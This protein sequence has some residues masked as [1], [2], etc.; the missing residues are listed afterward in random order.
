MAPRPPESKAQFIARLEQGAAEGRDQIRF[1]AP[2]HTGA[3]CREPGGW[4]VRRL[5]SDRAK[6]E[7]YLAEHGTFMPEHAEMLAVPGKVL[8][9]AR[10][11]AEL[12]A[13]LDTWWPG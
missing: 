6:E 12:I 5:E 1:G 8:V 10:P 7:Q 13:T 9:E 3:V 11:L 2:H 4:A